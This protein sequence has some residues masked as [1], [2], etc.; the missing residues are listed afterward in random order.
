MLSSGYLP[1]NRAVLF[2]NLG[3]ALNTGERFPELFETSSDISPACYRASLRALATRIRERPEQPLLEHIKQ[4]SVFLP[5]E[6]R[7]IQFGLATLKIAEVFARL[8]DYYV[9]IGKDTNRLM[10]YSV[11]LWVVM[12]GVLGLFLFQLLQHIVS[13]PGAVLLSILGFLSMLVGLWLAMPQM[14]RIWIEPDSKFWL[15]GARLPLIRSM[16][17]ARSV[18]QYLLNLGLCIQ[19]GFDFD[20][21][22]KVTAKSEAIP[23]LRHRYQTVA[24][25]VAAGTQISKAFMD[26][27]IL[28]ETR[29]YAGQLNSNQAI[30]IWEPGIIDVVRE[31]YAL[32]LKRVVYWLPL[33]L[34][35]PMFLLGLLMLYIGHA[36][37]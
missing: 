5:W 33:T 21:S 9:L 4:S 24:V 18:Y 31:S 37:A 19:G 6:I 35:L 1:S 14:L 28:S 15:L 16:M 22:L 36:G 13:G 23:W 26:S 12:S 34:V 29:I 20:R 11:C 27:G 32:Q 3:Q 2:A 8:C 30:A 17:V 25:D 7:Y 10:I